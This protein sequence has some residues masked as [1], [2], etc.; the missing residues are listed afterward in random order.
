[1]FDTNLNAEYRL[2]HDVFGLD[3]TG[4]A[5]IAA[6]GVRAAFCPEPLRAQLLAEIADVLRTVAPGAARS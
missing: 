4:L 2:C 1:M 5:D 3:P 6:A